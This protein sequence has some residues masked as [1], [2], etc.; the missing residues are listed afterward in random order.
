MNDIL[1]AQEF[2]AELEAE[3]AS[4]IKCLER[5]KPE[6]F[7]F[8]PHERSMEMGYLAQLVAEIPAWI[9]Y[10]LAH[11]HIDFATY[12][13]IKA[14]NAEQ[15]VN[16][17]KQNVAKSKDALLAIK[18]GLLSE[19]FNLQT[20]GQV[21]LQSTRGEQLKSM[22]NHLVHHRGQLTVYMRLNDIPV[23]SIY[24]PS[25]DDKSFSS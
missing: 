3:S 15:L 14:E 16:Y 6:L 4:S 7:G 2:A 5:M 18:E 10:T 1:F 9:S 12:P 22:I 8:K 21:L 11:P 19:D 25:A 24:G 20:N 13:H 23:P 17:F